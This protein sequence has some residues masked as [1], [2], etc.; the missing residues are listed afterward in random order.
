MKTK[1]KKDRLAFWGRCMHQANLGCILNICSSLPAPQLPLQCSD[2]RQHQQSRCSSETRPNANEVGDARAKSSSN[3]PGKVSH[4]IR[5]LR[6]QCWTRVA[7]G[8]QKCDPLWCGGKK[9]KS[10]ECEI[11]LC[12]L[13]IDLRYLFWRMHKLFYPVPEGDKTS[14]RKASWRVDQLR[15]SGII[16]SSPLRPSHRTHSSSSSFS[17]FHHL[18]SQS[19]RTNSTNLTT[20]KNPKTM[21]MMSCCCCC[22]LSSSSSSSS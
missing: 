7:Q 15:G 8:E 1:T 21:K 14:K 13:Y 2:Q 4:I 16:A 6:G 5:A 9:N 18:Q 12:E 20:T 19:L 3:I 11:S 22:C 17:P 10:W